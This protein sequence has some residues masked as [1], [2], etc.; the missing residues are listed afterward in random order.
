MGEDF[1]FLAGKQ[2]EIPRDQIGYKFRDLFMNI[3]EPEVQCSPHQ[4]Q[5][6]QP[7]CCM[8]VDMPGPHIDQK[9]DS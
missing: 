3:T 7:L 2:R 4:Q 8:I 1:F 9:L 5:G 6:Y